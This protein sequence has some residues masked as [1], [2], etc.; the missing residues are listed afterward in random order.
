MTYLLLKKFLLPSSLPSI[1]ILSF[2]S[3]S[4][5]FSASFFRVLTLT[6]TTS[7]G[8]GEFCLLPALERLGRVLQ[9]FGWR[10][11]GGTGE[12]AEEFVEEEV[13]AEVEVA[14]EVE[15]EVEVELEVE[16]E[17]EVEVEVEVEV[18]MEVE[19]EVKVEA[20]AEAKA[21]DAE[22]GALLDLPLER[23]PGVRG[24]VL[25]SRELG[26]SRGV[27]EGGGAHTEL[28]VVASMFILASN[29]IPAIL[30]LSSNLLLT[31]VSGTG[32]HAPPI[33][34]P[35]CTVSFLINLLCNAFAVEEIT[36][37]R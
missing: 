16:V 7:P 32:L 11:A 31:L 23:S 2:F 18:K 22:V 36:L 3:F 28:F 15:V 8:R 37:L 33:K 21:G 25:G 17:M 9:Y 19:V 24:G 12:E 1:A 14:P 6:V 35:I 13:A 34:L 4:D 10:G 26:V 20:K 27:T 5:L 29:P 30:P